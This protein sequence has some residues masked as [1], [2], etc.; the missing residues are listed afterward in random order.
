VT[1]TI[2]KRNKGLGLAY[3]SHNAS[4][5][6]L[7]ACQHWKRNITCLSDWPIYRCHSQL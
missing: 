6:L 4:K 5:K 7:I 2:R 1:S 3:S